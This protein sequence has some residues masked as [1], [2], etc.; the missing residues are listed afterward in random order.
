MKITKKELP[1]AVFGTWE[2]WQDGTLTSIYSNPSGRQSTITIYPEKL[3]EPDLFITLRAEKA[4]N[5]W[6]D[7][8]DAFFTAC[9]VLKITKV[10]EFQT[11]FD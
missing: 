3:T 5:D 2:V 8:V 7:F 10:K 1:H 9:E 6:N 11:A 4:V